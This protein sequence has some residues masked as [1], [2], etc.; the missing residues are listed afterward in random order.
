MQQ[1]RNRVLELA[2][3]EYAAELCRSWP[4]AYPNY[5]TMKHPV[6]HKWFGVVMDVP[7]HSLDMPE[8]SRLD[9]LNVKADPLLIVNLVH[10]EGF[11]PAWHMNKEHWITL[12]LDGSVP[13]D[14]IA[15]LL[16]M[17]Y[18]LIAPRRKSEKSQ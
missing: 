16:D 17:S 5:I 18:G 7:G 10:Q 12:R 9:I 1:L 2:Q 6:N 14:Q 8:L 15:A 4:E 3:S 11:H 13:F